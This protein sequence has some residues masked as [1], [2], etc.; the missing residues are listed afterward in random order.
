MPS[1]SDAS[2]QSDEKMDG[3]CEEEMGHPCGGAQATQA[4]PADALAAPS[5]FQGP[6][7]DCKINVLLGAQ[8]NPT[9]SHL[10]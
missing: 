7:K 1:L 9:Q 10:C 4:T 3:I 6:D 2:S 5:R 8:L